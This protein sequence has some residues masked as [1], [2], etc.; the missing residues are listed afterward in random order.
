VVV[1]VEQTRLVWLHALRAHAR[2]ADAHARA[3]A[4]FARMGDEANAVAA[5]KLAVIERGIFSTMVTSHPE[6]V[7]STKPPTAA[8]EP[9][10]S[11]G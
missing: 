8:R 10:P 4:L 2:A 1:S 3:A 9:G 7:Q 5:A 11:P 6:W